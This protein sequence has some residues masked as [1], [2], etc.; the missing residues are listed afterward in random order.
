[1]T[2][3][4][5]MVAAVLALLAAATVARAADPVVIGLEIPLSPPGDPT[6]GQ[7]IRRGGEL[8]IEYIN[9]PMGGVL[10][11]RKAALAVQ[12]SQGRTE[13]GIAAYRRL[14]SEDRA[15]AVTGFFHSSVNLA[16]NEV[17]KELG[18]PTIATQASASDI[19]GKHYD[20]AFRTHVIDPVRVS[21]WLDFIKAKNF[22]RVAILAETTDYGIG[23]AEETEKQSKQQKLAVEFM[24]VT[25]DHGSTDLTP[26]LLQVKAFRPDLLVNI[27]VG[28]PM[29]LMV[30]QAA[31]LG[32]T[33]QSPMLV[34]YDAPIRPQFWQLHPKTGA[35]LYFIAY[36]S[37]KQKL[38][39]AGEWFA[40]A[41][42]AKYNESP[43][44]SSLNGFGDVL[45][46][47]QAVNQAKSADPK[48]MIKALET[49]TF[50]SWTSSP[51][52]FPRADGVFFHN[53]SPPVLILQYTAANQDWKEANVIVE[54]AGS[55]P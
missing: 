22:K 50:K 1:M 46:V 33:P 7:L 40:K 37:P 16:A 15:V 18:V 30:E 13:S 28:Q 4:L 19:T 6:A 51:V 42:E 10:G 26:L 47:A 43:V 29:D 34:S 31:T 36:Y 17:A 12:D 35:G 38:S 2:S 9:G 41:Y 55:A 32:I 54:H 45:I 23:L 8:A 39:D 49:G 27:G 5:R 24:I 52:T 48:A 44:Y 21:A 11:D 25:F 20:V 3:M 14:V 53:W